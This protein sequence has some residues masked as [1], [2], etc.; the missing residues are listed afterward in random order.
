VAGAACADAQGTPFELR[1]GAIVDCAG[2]YAR[3]VGVAMGGDA[4]A[5]PLANEVHAKAHYL[6]LTS[7][8]L[9]MTSYDIAYGN[10]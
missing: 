1:C 2:P 5:L 3:A 9:A 10:R 6:L 8:H 4:A 7:Y